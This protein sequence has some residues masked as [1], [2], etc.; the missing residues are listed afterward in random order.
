MKNPNARFRIERG[1]IESIGDREFDRLGIPMAKAARASAKYAHISQIYTSRQNLGSRA[2]RVRSPTG[3]LARS[4]TDAG[5]LTPFPRTPIVA[6]DGSPAEPPPPAAPPLD[7][8]AVVTIVVTNVVRVPPGDD[9]D[10]PDDDPDA[11]SLARRDSDE[12]SASTFIAAGVVGGRAR[13]PPPP[14]SDAGRPR[15]DVGPELA[16]EGSPARESPRDP[17]RDPPRD[18][19][20]DPPLDPSLARAPRATA[21]LCASHLHSNTLSNRGASKCR[22]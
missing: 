8:P 14:G 5:T 21:R 1:P 11:S 3:A 13:R 16:R 19:D 2:S 18:P 12:A 15:E 20:R 10:D 6:S 9:D 17:D 7:F 22:R 4:S